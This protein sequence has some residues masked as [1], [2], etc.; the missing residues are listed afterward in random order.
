MRVVVVLVPSLHLSEICNKRIVLICLERILGTQLNIQTIL[1]ER[2]L[3]REIRFIVTTDAK[4]R[5]QQC[6]RGGRTPATRFLLLAIELTIRWHGGRSLPENL[7]YSVFLLLYN[8]RIIVAI[9]QSLLSGFVLAS[10]TKS[11]AEVEVQ[12]VAII[13]DVS[14]T[15]EVQVTVRHGTCTG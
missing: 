11:P 10:T 3:K 9:A 8:T 2:L 5:W 7:K 4:F 12:H 1:Q 6:K 13:L 15:V 14:P